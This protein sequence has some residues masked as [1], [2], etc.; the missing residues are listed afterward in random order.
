MTPEINTAAINARTDW[1][2]T[3]AAGPLP[4]RLF[5]FPGV[6]QFVDGSGRPL[7][8]TIVLEGFF[9]ATISTT[10]A[11]AAAAINTLIDGYNGGTR[12]APVALKIHG[13]TYSSVR[14]LACEPVGEVMRVK[15]GSTNKMIRPVRLTF[16]R[17]NWIF[18]TS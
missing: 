10:A 14:L 18:T 2:H 16:Q 11:A 12:G 17:L 6:N 7:P 13:T 5:R 1:R 15:E 9:E 8:G 4:L 3:V